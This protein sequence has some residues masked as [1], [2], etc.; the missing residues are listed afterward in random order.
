MLQESDLISKKELLEK[1]EISYGQLYRW[2]RERLIP[3]DWFVKQSTFTGQETF[4]PRKPILQRIKEIKRLKDKHSLGELAEI[5]APQ[6]DQALELPTLDHPLVLRLPEL[7]EREELKTGEVAFAWGLANLTK[8]SRVLQ[9][10]LENLI[11]RVAPVLADLELAGTICTVFRVGSS[12]NAVFSRGF[13]RL[14]FDTGVKE[15]GSFALDEA[16]RGLRGAQNQSN[17]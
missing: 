3:E 10:S 1:T 14:N 5:L 7:L 12:L 15:I 8:K 9:V 16:L 17:H 13:R 4:F 2:K 6:S 11:L